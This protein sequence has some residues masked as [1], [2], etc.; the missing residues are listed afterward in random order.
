MKP[1]GSLATVRASGSV[2]KRHHDQRNSYNGQHLTG[3]A[4]QVQKFSPLLSQQEGWQ[5]PGTHSTGGAERSTSCCKSRQE[6]NGFQAARRRVSQSIKRPPNSANSN[7]YSARVSLF[8]R[9]PGLASCP[10]SVSASLAQRLQVHIQL[11]VI[12]KWILFNGVLEVR[13][14]VFM[15]TYQALTEPSSQALV[16]ICLGPDYVEQYKL[17]EGRSGF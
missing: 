8:I 16:I 10:V 1:L 13:T 6:K 3:A 5:R 17:G 15:L 4:L 7:Q 9:K 11:Y 14:R 2:V 12:K